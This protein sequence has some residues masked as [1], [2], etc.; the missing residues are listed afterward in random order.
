ME[1]NLK[2][3]VPRGTNKFVVST[4][5]SVCMCI[6]VHVCVC[7]CMCVCVCVCAC[8]RVCECEAINKE[9]V[10]YNGHAI[11]ELVLG[12]NHFLVVISL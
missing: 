6:C 11:I 4:I 5:N 7:A 12:I 3:E 2:Q 10:K 1:F 8:V 9:K